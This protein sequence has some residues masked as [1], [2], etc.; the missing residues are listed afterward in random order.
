MSI[1]RIVP[2]E[3]T[4]WSVNP[5]QNWL[6]NRSV[7]WTWRPPEGHRFS[8]LLIDEQHH[9]ET[10]AL[11]VRTVKMLTSMAAVQTQSQVV[12]EFDPAAQRLHVHELVIWRMAADGAWQKREPVPQEAFLLRKREQQFEQQMLK[13]HVSLV[14]LLEDVR[15]GDVIDLSWTLEPREP[16]PG[17]LFTSLQFLVWT[18]PV[19]SYFL[20]LHLFSEHAVHWRL[21]AP[22][23][24]PKPLESAK[25]DQVNWHFDH[26]PIFQAEGN[27][28][29]G[30]WPFPV[31]EFTAWQSWSQVARFFRELWDDALNED[32]G[33]VAAEAERLAEGKTRA[34]AILAALRFVQQEV[35]YLSVDFGHGA[36]MLP[37]G[38]G[39]VLRR[40][41]GDCKDKTI[42][43]TAL[44]RALGVSTKPL[45]VAS[46]W[47]DAIKRLLPTTACFNHA[48]VVFE[49]D[50]KRYF[51]DPTLIGQGGDLEHLAT[52]PFGVGLEQASR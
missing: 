30:H 14:S 9:V 19:A 33:S 44:L 12:I 27:M 11:Y 4:K 20:T 50:G 49:H 23:D 24:A 43:L 41:F 13:G 40:R 18:A 22:A 10:Q 36:G 5:P 46:V 48:I 47:R 45:L 16:L 15:V 29:G 42:L 37:N 31:L 35:R 21:H 2:I 28:P 26:P 38:A 51:A 8:Y 34:D 25:A 1:R 52:P 6:Q 3:E 7:D 17:L 39:T 32:S